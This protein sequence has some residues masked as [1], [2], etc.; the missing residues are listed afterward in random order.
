MGENLST[1]M[2]NKHKEELK[3]QKKSQ[4]LMEEKGELDVEEEKRVAPSGVYS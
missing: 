2:S 4:H 1:V 3:A